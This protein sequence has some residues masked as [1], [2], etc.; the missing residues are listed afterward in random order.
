M[1]DAEGAAERMRYSV[2]EGE[3]AGQGCPG[4]VGAVKQVGASFEI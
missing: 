4:E 3:A 2:L 1:R